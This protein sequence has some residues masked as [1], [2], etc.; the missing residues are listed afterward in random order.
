LPKR[1]SLDAKVILRSEPQYYKTYAAFDYNRVSTELLTEDE[2]K[3]LDYICARSSD[4]NEISK[5]SDTN[6]EKCEKFLNRM[7]RLGYVQVNADSFRVRLPERVKADS[8]LYERF[9]LPFL[10]APTS[11]DL[12]ITSRC[13]L[14]CA[15]CFSGS[16]DHG[17]H[18]LSVEEIESILDQLETLGV[19]ELRINGGEPLLHPRINEILMTLKPRRFRKVILTNGTQLDEEKARLL[20]ESEATPTISVDDSSAEGHDL[21][22]GVKGSFQRT[23]EALKLLQKHGVEYG[24]NCCLHKRNLSNHRKIIDLAVSYGARRIAFLDL[25]PSLEMKRN[26]EWMPSYREYQEVL[27]ELIVDRI[28]YARKID[29]ALDTFLICRPLE[30][31]VKEARRGYVCCQAGRSRLSID[32]NGSIYPCNLVISDPRWNMGN[33]RTHSISESWFSNRWSFFRGEVRT[34]ELKKCKDCKKLVECTDFYCRLHPYL[35]NGDPYG[36]HPKCA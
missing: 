34:S 9:V 33:I 32:S 28:R 3:I 2:Y 36:P 19:L 23:I 15:H 21:F 8:T 10:S 4:A 6:E 24:I 17:V 18:E 35:V 7:S 16:E 1:Y 25:K 29:V 30:E 14:N 12:F 13:N 27:P 5:E 22:R 11:V 26:I 31:S 20:K